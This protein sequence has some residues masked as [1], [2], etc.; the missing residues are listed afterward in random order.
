MIDQEQFLDNY[1]KQYDDLFSD[2]F[3]SRH[4]QIVTE[5]IKTRQACYKIIQDATSQNFLMKMREILLH[6]AYLQDLTFFADNEK[7]MDADEE[8]ITICT[9]GSKVYY[10]E[11]LNNQ[12]VKRDSDMLLLELMRKYD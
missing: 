4:P 8:T 6:D 12:L 1:F 2:E 7:M 10:K 3:K 5:Y 11:L 9:E